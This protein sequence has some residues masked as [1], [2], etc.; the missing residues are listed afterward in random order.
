MRLLVDHLGLVA[1]IWINGFD[2]CLS[3][4]RSCMLNVPSLQA[5]KTPSSTPAEVM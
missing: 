2:D 1:S 4:L 5:S 3:L